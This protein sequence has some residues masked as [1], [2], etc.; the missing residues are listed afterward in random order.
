MTPE[1]L[2]ALTA[3]EHERGI[4]VLFAAES[5]SRAWGFASPDSDYDVR[6]V[7]RHP[8]DWYLGVI[9][10]RDVIERMLP[11]DLDVSG[12]D[13]RKS[14]RLFARGN[15]ALYEWL[16]SP[17]IYR[18]EPVFAQR[19]RELLPRYFQPASALHHYLGTARTTFAEHL[20][21][22]TV[23]L[24]KVFYF[25]RPV[26]ACRWIE[27]ARTQPPTAFAELVAA[28]WVDTAERD[29]VAELL[30]RKQLA[31][32]SDREP[33]DPALKQWMQ[34]QV[35]HFTRIGPSLARSREVDN[36]ELDALMVEL[37]G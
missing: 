3:L 21:G 33:L 9:E 29:S 36:S 25:L 15:V 34:A 20:G 8:R 17:I 24:K 30:R 2:A 18:E 26:L 23:R 16:G 37:C 13:L 35:D 6:F 12:W 14:L 5:G 27:H 31:S 1:I 28:D 4:Q 7:Y 10:A 19:L 22:D 32:E 11:N